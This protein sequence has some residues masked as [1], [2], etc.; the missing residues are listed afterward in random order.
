MFLPKKSGDESPP[1]FPNSPPV[2]PEHR[3]SLPRITNEP[4]PQTETKPTEP[5][6]RRTTEGSL[7]NEPS[8]VKGQAL[9][10]PVAVGAAPTAIK[11]SLPPGAKPG[12]GLGGFAM[13]SANEIQQKRLSMRPVSEHL[14]GH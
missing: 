10:V 4:G 12:L 6:M 13:P 3:I 5:R 7:P 2:L 14:V 8:E 9:T 1:S 11:R